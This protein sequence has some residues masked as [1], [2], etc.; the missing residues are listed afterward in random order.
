MDPHCGHPDVVVCI[1]G[2]F[3]HLLHAGYHQVLSSG[4]L[5]IV[6]VHS[7]PSSCEGKIYTFRSKCANWLKENIVIAC[8]HLIYLVLV[9][10]NVNGSNSSK[11]IRSLCCLLGGSGRP[12]H[13]FEI[14]GSCSVVFSDIILQV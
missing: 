7:Q 11:S 6:T 10:G 2:L 3:G 5:V 8:Y 1:D 9:T 12:M 14:G 13:S 4:I